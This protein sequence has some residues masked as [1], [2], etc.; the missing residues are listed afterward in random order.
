MMSAILRRSYCILFVAFLVGAGGCGASSESGG[1]N[2]G[3]AADD[4]PLNLVDLATF[5]R[6]PGAVNPQMKSS[7][8]IMYA[9][10]GDPVAAYETI[11]KQLQAERWRELPGANV[12]AEYGY[13]NGNFQ[14]HGY[15]LSVSVSKDTTATPPGVQ[16]TL[17][18]LGQF[19]PKTVP[20]PADAKQDYALASTAGYVTDSSVEATIAATKKA[21]A[22][23]SWKPYGESPGLFHFIKDRQLIGANISSAPAKGGKTMIQINPHLAAAVIPAPADVL[24]LRYFEAPSRL[25]F[26]HAGSWDDVAK[27]YQAELPK[28][29]W[30]P[31]TEN[32]V[33]N[34]KDGFQIYRNPEQAFLELRVETYGGQTSAEVEY[35][36]PGQFAADEQMFKEAMEKKKAEEAA[37][38]TKPN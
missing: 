33:K 21:F 35:K 8:M 13:A 32:L 23:A 29:G 24:E 3:G 1:G 10:P 11:K 5:A 37:K 34:E 22:D 38:G 12:S 19:D 6:L 9:A 30:Q 20:L 18:H 15:L 28:L 25:E 4:G 36:S 26:K 14:H 31:T 17:I 16:V 2:S 27:F 7:T